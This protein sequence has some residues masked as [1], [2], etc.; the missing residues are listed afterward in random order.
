MR[1]RGGGDRARRHLAQLDMAGRQTVR[2]LVAA[3]TAVFNSV[4]VGGAA[5]RGRKGKKG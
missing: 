4:P 1:A 2:R 3:A 5:G